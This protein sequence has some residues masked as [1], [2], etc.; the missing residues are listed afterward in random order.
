MNIV[1]LSKVYFTD[2]FV[3]LQECRQVPAGLQGASE[4]RRDSQEHGRGCVRDHLQ[5][6]AAWR[7]QLHQ[8]REDRQLRGGDSRPVLPT[9]QL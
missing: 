2:F 4:H 3:C 1:Y 6:A 8:D 7:R 5:L 9:H